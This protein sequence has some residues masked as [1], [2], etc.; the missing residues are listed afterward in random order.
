MAIVNN[1]CYLAVSLDTP[2]MN[3]A[4]NFDKITILWMIINITHWIQGTPLLHE[5][6]PAFI[7]MYVF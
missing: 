6:H 5:H 3:T 4:Y 1:K 2:S 7:Y